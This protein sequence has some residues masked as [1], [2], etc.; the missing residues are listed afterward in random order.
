MKTAN[1]SGEAIVNEQDMLFNAMVLAEHGDSLRQFQLAT[2]RRGC[3]AARQ[4]VVSPG[5]PV[6][7]LL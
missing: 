7:S 5:H 3:T 4:T 6:R 1:S 2:F